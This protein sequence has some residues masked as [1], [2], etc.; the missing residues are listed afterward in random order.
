MKPPPCGEDISCMK[1]YDWRCPQWAHEGLCRDTEA[2]AAHSTSHL[3]LAMEE[4]CALSCFLAQPPPPSPPPRLPVPPSPPPTPPPS[5]PT[6][7]KLPYPAP[8]VA[9]QASSAFMG[10]D[11][12][13]LAVGSLGILAC[14]FVA[15]ARADGLHRAELHDHAEE[16]KGEV[17][18][19]RRQAQSGVAG[20]LAAG[21]DSLRRALPGLLGGASGTGASLRERPRHTTRNPKLS[22]ATIDPDEEIDGELD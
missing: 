16:G 12:A 11:G 8:P 4:T 22:V 9:V 7:P 3:V 18:W 15:Y 5:P 2:A 14:L 17:S 10:L 21:I 20:S 1:D 19:E 13:F 6:P